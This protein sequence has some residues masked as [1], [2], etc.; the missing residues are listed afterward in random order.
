M[1]PVGLLVAASSSS[2]T[3]LSLSCCS[4]AHLLVKSHSP[5]PQAVRAVS[6]VCRKPIGAAAQVESLLDAAHC[7]VGRVLCAEPS[8]T[9]RSSSSSSCS[10][11][12]G[13]AEGAAAHDV[14]RDSV[15]RLV[16][17]DCLPQHLHAPGS[18]RHS[19]PT[20]QQAMRAQEMIAGCSHG[21]QGCLAYKVSSRRPSRSANDHAERVR[22]AHPRI[23]CVVVLHH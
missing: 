9:A 14:A 4:A 17:L 20:P 11:F 18:Q 7:S 21:A 23:C 8:N 22:W 3:H 10:V 1:S 16:R 13:P 6:T 15:L 5:R 19:E 12:Q 2:Q